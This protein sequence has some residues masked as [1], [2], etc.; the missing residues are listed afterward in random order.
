MDYFNVI[1]LL[2]QTSQTGAKPYSYT[3]HCK[4]SLYYLHL[5]YQMAVR[6]NANCTQYCKDFGNRGMT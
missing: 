5:D 1:K 4:V 2:I 3:F 6:Q